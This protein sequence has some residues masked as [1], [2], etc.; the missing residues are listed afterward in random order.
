M[1]P[2]AT[3]AIPR[4]SPN[5][6]WDAEAWAIRLDHGRDPNDAYDMEPPPRRG[7]STARELR[8]PPSIVL[9]CRSK[10]IAERLQLEIAVDHVSNA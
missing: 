2:A 8:T 10:E 4:T 6:R 3:K 1:Q 9:L 7:Q 5:Q